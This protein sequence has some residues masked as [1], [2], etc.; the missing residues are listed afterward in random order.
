MAVRRYIS[1]AEVAKCSFKDK[2]IAQV[3]VLF[4]FPVFY[5]LLTSIKAISVAY[6]VTL[7]A[8]TTCL[9]LFAEAQQYFHSSDSLIYH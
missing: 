4:F 1:K 2:A 9:R 5:T 8:I 6:Q 3:D 7:D